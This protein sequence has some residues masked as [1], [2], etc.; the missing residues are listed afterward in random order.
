M[1]RFHCAQ[2]WNIVLQSSKVKRI[3]KFT[4]TF[5][6]F[7]I[8]KLNLLVV[9]SVHSCMSTMPWA[10]NSHARWLCNNFYQLSFLEFDVNVF[11]W[12]SIF[13][14]HSKIFQ[15]HQILRSCS[16]IFKSSHMQLC[17]FKFDTGCGSM[18][19]GF[20]FQII[21]SLMG[22]ME[23]CWTWRDCNEIVFC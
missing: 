22:S 17:W 12:S 3:P 13:F 19:F 15:S 16:Q 20:I 6:E 1:S 18:N 8:W 7:I 23:V 21:N 5:D 10:E 14:I 11:I 2:I 4:F 9:E